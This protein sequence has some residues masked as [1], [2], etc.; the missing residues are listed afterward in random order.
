MEVASKTPSL[1]AF[2]I[3]WVAVKMKLKQSFVIVLWTILLNSTSGKKKD[4]VIPYAINTIIEQHFV[5]LE[6]YPGR[7]D[8]SYVG[9]NNL[10]F[11][12]LMDKLFKIKSANTKVI[13]SKIE[14]VKS[15]HKPN[16]FY[17]LGDSGIV[18]FDSVERF[19]ASSSTIFWVADARYRNQHLVY[20]PGLTTSDIIKTFNNGFEIDDINFL[21][22]ETDNTVELVS[23][24]MYTPQACRQLQLKTIN[25]FNLGDVKWDNSIFYTKKYEN[26]HGCEL[27]VSQTDLGFLNQEEVQ[28]LLEMVFV[29]QLN[30]TLRLSFIFEEADLTQFS[31]LIL[32]KEN[33]IFAVSDPIWYIKYFFAIAPGEPYTDLERMFM[34]FEFELWVAISATL[35][36]ALFATLMLHLVSRKVRNFIVGR[37]VQNPTMNML[38][39][40]LSGGQVQT[41]ARNFARFLFILFVIWSL[42]IR[43]CHQSMLFELMQADLRKPTIETLDEFFTSDLTLYD[44]N[45]SL[46]IDKYFEEQMALPTTRLVRY[47]N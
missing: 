46:L 1:L 41:P 37:Y 6:T 13:V 17:K 9:N 31:G 36:I 45:S 23:S 35:A 32:D 47:F 19:V 14:L 39:I 28:K 38:S 18:I 4:S 10:E 40:F 42:I 7:V 27:I 15:I 20:V 26:F 44:L 22:H 34:M 12:E 30:A 25:R 11:S 8:I 16:K 24:F 2:S 29:D 5:N 21:M 3:V 43:T 33:E